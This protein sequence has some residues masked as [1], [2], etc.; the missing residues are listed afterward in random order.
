[1]KREIEVPHCDHL[2]HY[3]MHPFL[4]RK[5]VAGVALFSIIHS[6]RDYIKVIK[7]EVFESHQVKG[8]LNQFNIRHDY[9]QLWY[10]IQLESIIEMHIGEMLNIVCFLFFHQQLNNFEAFDFIPSPGTRTE[11]TGK[12]GVNR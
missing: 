12:K 3:H 11:R 1:M 9:T 4:I 2:P 5:K 6:S 8:W 10:L 7:N